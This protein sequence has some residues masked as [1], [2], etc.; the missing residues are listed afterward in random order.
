[1][2]MHEITCMIPIL[3]HKQ[4]AHGPQ[5][6]PECAVMKAIFSQNT[7]NVACKKRTSMLKAHIFPNY[8]NMI[9]II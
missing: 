1:M 4:E 6:S 9:R 7:V 3:L 5:R 8:K 2:L